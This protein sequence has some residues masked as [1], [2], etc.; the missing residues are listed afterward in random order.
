MTGGKKGPDFT[1]L[2]AAL[3]G[4]IPLPHSRVRG[5]P[6]FGKTGRA[7]VPRDHSGPFI[8]RPKSVFCRSCRKVVYPVFNAKGQV[9]SVDPNATGPFVLMKMRTGS[10]QA[11]PFATSEH[12][13]LPRWIEHHCPPRLP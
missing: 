6:Y 7:I 5:A 2:D 11:V 9:A 3:D 12:N 10:P 4:D 1:R 13:G 8:G